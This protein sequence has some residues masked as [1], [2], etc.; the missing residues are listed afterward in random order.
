MLTIPAYAKINLTLEVLGQYDDGYHEVASVIQLI[1][2]HDTLSFELGEDVRLSCDVPQLCTDD[3]LVIRAAR[4]LQEMTKS[5]QGALITLRKGI[6]SGSGLGGGSSD[7]AAT[8]KA[9]NRLWELN[10]PSAQLAQLASTIGSDVAFFLNSNTALVTGRGEK[11]SPVSSPRGTWVVLLK[12]PFNVTEKTRRMYASL[13]SCH[14]TSGVMTQRMVEA[15]DCGERDFHSRCFNVFEG[16]AFSFFD[17]LDKYR[18]AFQDSGAPSVHLAGAGP[19]LYAIVPSRA[20]AEAVVS[21]LEGEAYLAQT[22]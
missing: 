14:W 7:A 11:V 9:L 4:L 13:E 18:D 8:L 12:P 6:P 1:D 15:L 19:A 5:Q 22:L 3:N 17:G 2:L 20:E 10:L 21:R 16:V